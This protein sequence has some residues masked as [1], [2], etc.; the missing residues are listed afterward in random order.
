MYSKIQKLFSQSSIDLPAMLPSA[1]LQRQAIRELAKKTIYKTHY[2]ITG[3]SKRKG[4]KLGEGN[5]VR[6]D[7]LCTGCTKLVGRK[8]AGNSNRGYFFCMSLWFILSIRILQQV[9]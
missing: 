9:Y 4:A 7:W 6:A 2:T 1:M 5:S 3:S 8:N